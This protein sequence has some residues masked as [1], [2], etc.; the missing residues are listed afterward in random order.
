MFVSD[1]L[2]FMGFI[3]GAIGGVIA[4][5]SLV[6]KGQLR[7]TFLNDCH[8]WRSIDVWERKVPD[9][10]QNSIRIFGS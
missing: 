7:K 6:I 10:S 9:Y 3:A 4:N 2:L 1:F 8:A 5:L